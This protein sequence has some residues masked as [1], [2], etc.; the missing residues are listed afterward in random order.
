MK[1]L[2]AGLLAVGA[3]YV[4]WTAGTGRALPFGIAPAAAVWVVAGLGMAACALGPLS[5]VA[6]TG[7]WTSPWAMAGIVVGVAALAAIAAAAYGVTFGVVTEPRQWILVLAALIGT[8]AVIA[9]AHV[10]LSAGAAVAVKG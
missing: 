3:I 8:K 9:T 7:D 2:A 10:L 6:A 5:T 4:A 1:M